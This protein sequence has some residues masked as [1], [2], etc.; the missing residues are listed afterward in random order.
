MYNTVDYIKTDQDEE[1]YHYML[2]EQKIKNDELGSY[3]TFG[4]KLSNSDL[5]IDDVSCDRLKAEEIVRHLN[6]HQVSPVHCYDVII[7]SIS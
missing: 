2:V 7:D 6:E 3:I 5:I 1:N 4:I